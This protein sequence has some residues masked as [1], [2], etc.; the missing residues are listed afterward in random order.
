[1]SDR[2]FTI[3]G[4]ETVFTGHV[5][6][7]RVEVVRF[8]DGTTVRRD[9]IR[10]PGAAAVVAFDDS[11]VHLVTQPRPAIGD[12]D[13]LE[14]PAGLLD[15]PGE[16]PLVAAQRELAE[17]VGLAADV[18]QHVVT[19]HPSV[20]VSDEETHLFAATALRPVG[21]RPDT[22]EEERIEIVRWPLADLDGALY[23]VRDGKTI[24]A[25]TWLR[26]RLRSGA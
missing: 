14:I 25:L 10:H 3:T 5:F 4:G 19:F 1:M 7:V 11:H 16:A 8:D 13:S 22:G 23:A 18:W 15:V 9:V 21:P 12:P 17:E 20:G 26:E 6:D 24:M 2:H